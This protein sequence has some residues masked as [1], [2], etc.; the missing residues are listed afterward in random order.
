[1]GHRGAQD[2]LSWLLLFHMLRASRFT[3]WQTPQLFPTC[4]H[5]F[6]E[7]KFFHTAGRLSL[8]L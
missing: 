6:S 3:G 8:G 2:V 1:M 4:M 7:E 5:M